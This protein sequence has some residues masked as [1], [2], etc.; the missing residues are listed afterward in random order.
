MTCSMLQV[1]PHVM[2]LDRTPRS[3]MLTKGNSYDCPL[4][5]EEVDVQRSLRLDRFDGSSKSHGDA[6]K[7][8][9]IYYQSVQSG[10]VNG[11]YFA[12]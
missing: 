3:Q 9:A 4:L 11:D 5:E 8:A 7:D 2:A 6:A 10:V 1:S 12:A